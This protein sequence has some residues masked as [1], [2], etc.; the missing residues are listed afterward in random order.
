M[1]E[2]KL[3]VIGKV[4]HYYPKMNVAVIELNDEI[5]VG[6]KI[7]IKGSTTNFE[8][9][10]ESIQIEKKNI[11]RAFAGQKIGLK[12]KDRVREKDIVYKI[13]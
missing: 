3:K 5:S 13:I 12:V 1:E 4:T 6:N 10:V 2:R 9:V 8:Q 11:E 7:L